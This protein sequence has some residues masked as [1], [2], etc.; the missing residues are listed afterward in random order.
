VLAASSEVDLRP[1]KYEERRPPVDPD[2]LEQAAKILGQA[3]HPM[4]F[5]GSGAIEAADAILELAEARRAPV[6]S[7]A[8][9]HGIISSRHY[10]SMRQQAAHAYWA[11]SDAV[12]AIGSRMQRILSGWGTDD[13]MQFI[14]IDVDPDEHRRGT[15][16][17]VSLVAYSE[18]VLPQLINA[19]GKHNRARASIQDELKALNN[20]VASK[21]AYLEPQLSYIRAIRDEL[22]DD[23]IFV[24]DMTQVGYVSRFAMPIYRPRT[25]LEPGY[26][27]TLGWSL[28]TS[29]GAKVANPDKQVISVSG[30]GGFMFNVQELATAVQHSI[31]IVSIVFDDGAY[32]NVRRMQKE[33]HGERFI[34]T[35]LQNP[36]FIQ[37]ADSFGALGLRA[38]NPAELRRAIRRGFDAD[39]PT[40]IEVPVEEMPNPSRI[41]WR[42]PR[43][44][45]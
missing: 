9:G 26:Q 31:N 44:R 7:S 12:L 38:E 5:V 45:G 18:D 28:P 21:I 30:D 33:L 2:A 41:A 3:K 13:Q 17:D 14:R 24:G 20:E 42:V 35:E 8:S 25:Y 4:I 10:L 19:T 15:R 40:I 11:K 29:I 39:R 27:G 43:V 32:G 16:P 1:V 36:N 34:A 37:L 22:D 6:G 23:G